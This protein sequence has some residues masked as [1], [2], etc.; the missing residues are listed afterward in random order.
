MAA[1]R[2]KPTRRKAADNPGRPIPATAS[3]VEETPGRAEEPTSK[4]PAGRE[5]YPVQK[6]F[7]LDRQRHRWL[8]HAAHDSGP[9]VGY[10]A[11]LRGVIDLLDGDGEQLAALRRFIA[12]RDI[13]GADRGRT[14]TVNLTTAQS[15]WLRLTAHQTGQLGITQHQLVHGLI[16]RLAAD[17]ATLAAIRSSLP[18]LE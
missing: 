12:D 6:K 3:R 7:L 4:R 2:D 16:D 18:T 1:P 8:V 11:L 10:V 14:I 17:P 13:T 9:S 5:N 15:D